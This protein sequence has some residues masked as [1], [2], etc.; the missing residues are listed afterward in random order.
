MS[1]QL[2][3]RIAALFYALNFVLG[4]LAMYWARSGRTAEA[5]QITVAAALDYAIV[6]ALLG[7]LF[8]PAGRGFSWSV[9]AIGIA[10]SALSAGDALHLFETPVNPLAVFG[11]YCIGLGGLLVRSPLLP[12]VIGWAL[13]VGGISWLTFA[14]PGLSRQLFPY[15]IAPGFIAEL[16]FTLW[17]LAFGVRERAAS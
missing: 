12:R 15:N 11:A 9:A 13:V 3:A 17:L 16:I 2:L 8:E 7:R 4:S 5:E 10:G 1:R 14:V 6:A